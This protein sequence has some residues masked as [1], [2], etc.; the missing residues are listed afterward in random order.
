[1][2]ILEV[3]GHILFICP[4]EHEKLVENEIAGKIIEQME[5]SNNQSK[6]EVARFR[7]VESL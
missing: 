4:T 2:S 7:K 5:S 3:F 6:T 1:V